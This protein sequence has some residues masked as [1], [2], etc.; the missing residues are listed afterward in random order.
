MLCEIDQNR[1]MLHGSRCVVRAR[2]ALSN[3][4][5]MYAC[6]TAQ[7]A[8]I[9]D[10]HGDLVETQTHCHVPFAVQIIVRID[11]AGAKTGVCW[12]S[13]DALCK[14]RPRKLEP[15]SGWLRHLRYR[16]WR[17]SHMETCIQDARFVDEFVAMTYCATGRGWV[18]KRETART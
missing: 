6:G 14:L 8:H 4:F 18:F 9:L 11:A 17:T 3:Q 15:N 7:K 10:F 2:C 16:A 12:T 13:W 1:P 5:A